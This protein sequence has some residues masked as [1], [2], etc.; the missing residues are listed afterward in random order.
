MWPWRRR[1]SKETAKDRLRLV[2]AYDRKS[3]PPGTVESLKADI[4]EVLRRYFPT[5]D[6]AVAVKL[7]ERDGEIVLVA[8]V[9]V[10]R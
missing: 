3:V 9:P 10:R 2:L 7:E 6:E 8:E 1:R 5:D 4:L